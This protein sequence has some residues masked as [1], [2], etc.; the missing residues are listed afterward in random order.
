MPSLRQGSIFINFIR[1]IN[2]PTYFDR[3][4]KGVF[5]LTTNNSSINSQRRFSYYG[6]KCRN[7]FVL[8]NTIK[9]IL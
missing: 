8:G 1:T 2:A 7:G 5:H 4:K 9:V 3:G 6:E